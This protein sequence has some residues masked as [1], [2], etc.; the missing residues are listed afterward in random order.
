MAFSA[1]GT[2]HSLP[3]ATSFFVPPPLSCCQQLGYDLRLTFDLS[4]ATAMN[5]RRITI[6][7][8]PRQHII[9][10]TANNAP[11]NRPVGPMVVCPM[12]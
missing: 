3:V 10:K 12:V 4:N 5:A 7:N 2:V 8:L 1:P 9:L 6:K 11:S